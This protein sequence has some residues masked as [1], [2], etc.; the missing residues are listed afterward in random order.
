VKDFPKKGPGKPDIDVGRDARVL[1]EPHF[2]PAA[3]PWVGNKYRFGGKGVF[4]SLKQAM[5]P[6]RQFFE[7]G[8]NEK[9]QHVAASSLP[10]VVNLSRQNRLKALKYRI[11]AL[12]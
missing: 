6:L 1:G 12:F 2:E 11:K 3:K 7:V 5:Q 4:P 8:V 9:G 10:N